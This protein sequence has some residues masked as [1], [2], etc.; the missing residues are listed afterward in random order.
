MTATR[1][2]RCLF[3]ALLVLPAAACESGG[4]FTILGYTTKP[5][6]DPNIR[7]VYVP[8]FDNQAI[9]HFRTGLEV[10]MTR[11]VVREIEARTPFKVVD[12]RSCA[13]TELTGRIVA[14]Q[15]NI[16]NRNQLNEVRE[17]ET[18][19]KCEIVWRDLRTGE[20]LS[21]PKPGP[22]TPAP[23]PFDEQNPPPPILPGKPTPVLVTSV[24]RFIPEVGESFATAQKMNVDRMAVS[25]VNLMEKPW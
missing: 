3:A 20:I 14:L 6:Y 1:L 2:A 21:Q 13:D 16:V 8:V 22:K 18:I 17:A 4:H 19:L 24:G 25:I 11:A 12:D 7:T 10:D 23:P 15:K 5:N 9:G